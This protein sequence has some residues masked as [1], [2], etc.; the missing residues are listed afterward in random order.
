MYTEEEKRKFI[1]RRQEDANE[2]LKVL[3]RDFYDDLPRAIVEVLDKIY[4][5]WRRYDWFEEAWDKYRSHVLEAVSAEKPIKAPGYI[6][7]DYID[8]QVKQDFLTEENSYYM[9]S[10]KDLNE[11]KHYNLYKWPAGSPNGKGG[12]WMSKEDAAAIGVFFDQASRTAKS[13]VETNITKDLDELNKIKLSS[14]AKDEKALNKK[15]YNSLKPQDQ[16][17][18]DKAVANVISSGAKA[19]TDILNQAV[20]PKQKS[21]MI[22]DKDYSQL[23]M[24]E[25]QEYINRVN[26]EKQYAI[27]KGE[28]KY[29]MTDFERKQNRANWF[30]AIAGAVIGIGSA[31]ATLFVI[32][33]SLS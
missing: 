30:N 2:D 14:I 21:K 15:V 11:L 28:V 22:I 3:K 24:K 25:M 26:T 23:T 17:K 6:F 7:K 32:K 5:R 4:W 31:I 20:R 27:A 13:S 8:E 10:D 1:I 33:K 18:V 19:T 12:E 16:A 9:H 29:E